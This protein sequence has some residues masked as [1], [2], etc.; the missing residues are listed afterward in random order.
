MPLIIAALAIRFAPSERVTGRRLAGLLL[1]LAGVV[2]LVG[3]D[4][5]GSTRE[6]V[7]AAAV[8]VTALG[9]SV[10][11]L[12]LDRQF[13]GTPTRA[14]SMGASLAIA[15]L[16]LAPFAALDRPSH[17]PTASALGATLG[18]AVVCTALAFVVFTVLIVEVGPSRA[19]VITYIN[20]VVA[21]ALGTVILG[22]H[23]GPGSLIGLV[24]ILTGS[25]IATVGRTRGAGARGRR[26]DSR[27]TRAD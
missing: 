20:P 17:S 16:V 2:A 5:A 3:I 10:G 18:L 21:V 6:L 14:R 22:E 27:L 12:I 25:W 26:G 19:S 15:A 1:G 7:G 9:Y 13:L 11:P 23:P 8:I 24:A 4:V